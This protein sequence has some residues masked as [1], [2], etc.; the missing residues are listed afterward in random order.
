MKAKSFFAFSMPR[1]SPTHQACPYINVTRKKKSIVNMNILLMTLVVAPSL[2]LLNIHPA[3]A[4]TSALR[5]QIVLQNSGGKTIQGVKVTAFGA[6]PT[7]TNSYGQFE[8]QF[9]D[10]RPGNSVRLTLIKS[11]LEVVNRKELQVILRADPDDLVLFVMCKEGERDRNAVI[12]YEIAERNINESADKKIAALSDEMK[13]SK[14]EIIAKIEEERQ[15]GL[16]QAKELSEKFA[17]VNLDEASEIYKEAFELFQQGNIERALAV[18][19][20]KKLD[21]NISDVK[22][23][24]EKAEKRKKDLKKALDQ[25]INS[26]ILKA[27]LSVTNLQFDEAD[28]SYKKAVEADPTN[29]IHLI[30]YGLFLISQKQATKAAAIFQK[31]AEVMPESEGRYIAYSFLGG[32]YIET[33]QYYKALE[34]QEKAVESFRSYVKDPSHISKEYISLAVPMYMRLASLYKGH[35][36]PDRALATY[37]GLLSFFQSIKEGY[38]VFYDE[39]LFRLAEVQYQIGKLKSDKKD[40]LI[41]LDLYKEYFRYI[42]G[43]V[44]KGEKEKNLRYLSS[45]ETAYDKLYGLYTDMELC[46]EA[47]KFF[48]QASVFLEANYEPKDSMPIIAK[49]YLRISTIH[50]LLAQNEKALTAIMQALNLYKELAKRNPQKYLP[51]VAKN[52]WIAAAYQRALGEYGN[53]INSYKEALKI[54][55]DLMNDNPSAYLQS[56]A[57]GY[58]YLGKAYKL[59]KK[60]PEALEAFRNS[61][62]Y[63]EQLEKANPK[64]YLKDMA[65]VSTKL[66]SLHDLLKQDTEASKSFD[67]GMDYYTQIERDNPQ[68]LLTEG[69]GEDFMELGFYYKK[70]KQY[71]KALKAYEKSKSIYERLAQQ[72]PPKYD[73]PFAFAL[74]SLS[75]LHITLIEREPKDSYKTYG[76]ETAEKA[77]NIL[78]K[79]PDNKRAQEYM[80]FAK[81]GKEYFRNA[82]ISKLLI[83]KDAR[84]SAAKGDEV[85]KSKGPNKEAE[86]YYKTAIVSYENLIRNENGLE[87]LS[88]LSSVYE[89]LYDLDKGV[90]VKRR[91]DHLSKL[92]EEVYQKHRNNS[93]AKATLAGECGTIAWHLVLRRKF[94]E[95]EKF[96]LRG[97]EIDSS[98][99]WIKINLAHAYLFQGKM[100]DAEGLYI[101]LKDKR[102]GGR[103]FKDEVLKDFQELEKAGLSSTGMARIKELIGK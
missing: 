83:L 1:R 44:K 85:I 90:S 6:N 22:L 84:E 29:W 42:E 7:I 53:S 81:E 24:I 66:G 36:Q 31:L 65:F 82:S 8:I 75:A 54:Y 86:E 11:G 16:K 26:Y 63:F 78:Q 74:V 23:E 10:K 13:K 62:K 102:Q 9:L 61:L 69:V 14:K 45:I 68:K 38:Q 30:D 28:K 32:L 87:Y 27:R 43:L 35:N 93:E 64:F 57:Q 4:E 97:L 73:L 99:E 51:E 58:E 15:L 52:R 89:S 95:S 46:D 79:Y 33:N 72:D 80:S 55:R 37:Q 92:V 71:D 56:V 48:E 103:I 2:V 49:N 50:M 94:Q 17:E 41:A 25:N 40:C 3:L 76:L 96:A 91:R 39:N 34:V 18:L 59:D 67:N 77:E 47:L 20:D 101:V 19:D 98:Q 12:Y 100:K 5:G 70:T 88:S 60:A 21:K